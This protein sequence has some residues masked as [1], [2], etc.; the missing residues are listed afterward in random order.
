MTVE[1]GFLT[2]VKFV[3]DEKFVM[4]INSVNNYY[5]IK[6]NLILELLHA[7]MDFYIAISESK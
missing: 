7:Y 4:T 6:D 1:L 5:I 3:S 2:I